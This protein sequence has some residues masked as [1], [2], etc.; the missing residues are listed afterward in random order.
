MAFVPQFAERFRSVIVGELM[1]CVKTD[2]QSQ[3]WL[4]ALSHLSRMATI[5]G[6][7]ARASPAGNPK[8]ASDHYRI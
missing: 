7:D 3:F 6:A 2:R 5:T 4:D 1:C 8:A